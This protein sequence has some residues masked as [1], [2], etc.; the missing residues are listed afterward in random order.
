MRAITCA[1]T[2]ARLSAFRDAELS[3]GEQVVVRS[4]V[5]GCAECTAELESLHWLGDALRSAS[6]ARLEFCREELTNL[7]HRA[8]PGVLAERQQQLPR[9]LERWRDDVHLVWALGAATVASLACLF[10]GLGVMRMTF[11][12]VPSSMAAVIG[13]LAHPGSDRNPMR[14]DGRILRPTFEQ[15]APAVTVSDEAVLAL[16]AVVTREG[17]VSR[18]ELVMPAAGRLPH[19]DAVLELLDAAAQTR[20]EP[21]RA[22]GAPVA[23]NVIWLMAHTTVIGKHEAEVVTATRPRVRSARP[24]APAAPPPVVEAPISQSSDLLDD[25]IA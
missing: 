1:E 5:A 14:L 15:T 19:H 16:S 8:L 24:Q 21:A 9:R 11:R 17:R 3:V 7:H 6:H 25:A 20:F 2:R 13:A 18:V 12:E 4:H 22:G 23:V 10:A